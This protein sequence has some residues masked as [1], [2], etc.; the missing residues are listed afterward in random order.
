MKHYLR[1][2]LIVASAIVAISIPMDYAL[3]DYLTHSKSRIF[4]GWN[5][6]IYD[7]IKADLLV[8]GSSRAWVQYDTYIIDSMLHTNSYNLGID[9]SA[10][11]RQ[12]LKYKVYEHYQCKPPKVLV[13]NMDFMSFKRTVGYER[14]Q[15][16][17]YLLNQYNRT[18]FTEEEPFSWGELWLPMFRYYKQGA[19]SILVNG[20]P[21]NG[22]HK[23]YKGQEKKWNGEELLKVSVYY[24]EINET[25][26]KEFDGFLKELKHQEVKVVFVLAPAYYGWK[27][28]V[29]NLPKFYETIGVFSD[30]YGFPILDYLDD[31][32]S[33]DTAYFYNAMHLNKKGAELF[34]VKLCQDLDSLGVLQ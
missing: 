32:L 29:D 1:T 6:V 20:G 27:E 19:Y 16:F 12:M 10:L 11:N 31:T 4:V 8:L 15:F 3:S 7:S 21:D 23:G 5:D 28:I 34:T 14:E 30:R 9:G 24:Y 2:I 26:T 18:V 22:L 17:P 13:L 25:V 33:Q